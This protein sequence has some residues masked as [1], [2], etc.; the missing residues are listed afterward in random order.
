[1]LH[2]LIHIM[3]GRSLSEAGR[4]PL[5]ERIRETT[6][7]AIMEAAEEVFA[8]QGLHNAH[9]GEIAAR[10]GVSVGTLYN[11]FEDREAL[12]AGLLDARQSELLALVD[13][14]L[15]EMAARPFAEQLRALLRC[16]L[17]HAEAHRKF[18]QILW[19]TEVG[20]YQVTFPSACRKPSATMKEILGRIDKV[21]KRGVKDRALRAEAGDLAP[22][23]FLGMVRGLCIRD[24]LAGGAGD[25]AGQAEALLDLFL[26][27]VGVR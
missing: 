7:R 6:E 18:F 8:D 22:L 4:K 19:Q 23:L 17:E 1:M 12:L 13:A 27:G 26:H 5:R 15:A 2:S 11:H 14:R 3:N 9:M 24:A 16:M 21:I 20:R 25:L 10:A